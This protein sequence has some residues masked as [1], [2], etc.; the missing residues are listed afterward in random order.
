L[1]WLV[2]IAVLAT[3][4]GVLWRTFRHKSASEERA[5][6]LQ[7]LELWIQGE[8]DEAAELLRQVVNRNPQ[9]VEPFL[10]LGDLLRLQ[11]DP[12]K[13]AILHRGLTVRSNLTPNQKLSVGLSLADDLNAMK[14]WDDAGRVLDTLIRHAAERP[15]YWRARFVQRQ[16]QGNLPEAARTLKHAPRHV[17]AREAAWFRKAY[18]SFQLDRALLHALGGEAAQTRARLRDVR[19]IPEARSRA[20]LVTATLAAVE[21]DAATAV[22][23]ATEQLLENPTE[24]AIF[25]PVLREVLLT[26]GHYARSIPILELACQADGSP[27]SLWVDLAM[28]YEKMDQRTRALHLLRSKAGSPGLTPNIAA[29]YLKMLLADV[30]QSDAAKVWRLLEAPGTPDGWTCTG[31]RHRTAHVRWFCASCGRFDS[32]VASRRAAPDK[33]ARSEA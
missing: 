14:C 1:L 18:A 28:L 32:F 13:A 24:L 27:P 6:Y 31:C 15:R 2:G 7:A 5:G 3:T 23:V 22:T 16:G 4:V 11:G 33:G 17:P 29:P 30:P 26:T 19:D 12:E 8:L 20:A 25:L 10:Y 9:A 21:N